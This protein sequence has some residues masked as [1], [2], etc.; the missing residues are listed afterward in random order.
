MSLP[1]TLGRLAQVRH[2]GSGGFADVWLYR[3]PQLDS[4]VAVKALQRGWAGVADIRERFLQEARLLRSVDS[5]Y[6]VRVHDIGETPD[7]IPYF[8]MA[9][10]DA[11]TVAEVLAQR[12]AG[13]GLQETAAIVAQAAEGLTALHARN[14]VHR[15]VKPANLLLTRTHDGLRVLI[16]DLGVARVIDGGEVTRDVGTPAYMSPEQFDPSLP[17]DRRSDVRS[18]AA[19][20]WA[21]LAGRSPQA[22][23]GPGARVPRLST[24]RSVLPSVDEVI[25]RGL[26][27]HPDDRWPDARTFAGE[28][29]RAAH[30][31]GAEP[32]PLLGELAPLV[33]ASGGLP[34]LAPPSRPPATPAMA[35]PA[36]P[37]PPPPSL[38]AAH[39][40]ASAA[41]RWRL[42]VPFA[43][44]VL[45][46][47]GVIAW[48][49]LRG[50]SGSGA[51]NA[52][53]RAAMKFVTAV[54]AGDCKDASLYVDPND[55]ASEHID[56][57]TWD[58]THDGWA[59]NVLKLRA[60]G[61]RRVE[62]IGDGQVRVVWVGQGSLVVSRVDG[63]G[64]S[65][66]VNN[67]VCCS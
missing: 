27:A 2:L 60:D 66:Y 63:S 43:V 10:A 20:A 47:G 40:P 34:P 9:Y 48:L 28:L 46:L 44:V 21:L 31:A 12:G 50:D 59:S 42:V 54:Q 35:P 15:D 53:E 45:V 32:G 64:I 3:D 37:P 19:V 13:L 22:A 67:I 58:C 62:D 52:Y 5:P 65:F 4:E 61:T 57:A 51:V 29:A 23:L 16:A 14:V 39:P 7:G 11:G 33:A 41:R 36:F 38:H 49:A 6:V 1:T 18:L 8:V 55:L 17:L 30:D 56:T 26:A 25:D 24:V